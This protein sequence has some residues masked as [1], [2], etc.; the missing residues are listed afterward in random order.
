MTA[1]AAYNTYTQ[2]NIQIESPEKLIEMLYEG[3]IRFASLAKKAIE[4][5]NVEKKVYYINRTTAI[6]IELINSLDAQRGGEIAHYLEGLYDQQIKFLTEA[7]LEND[8]NKIDIVLKVTRTLLE[9]WR[10]ETGLS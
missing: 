8:P 5:G 1:A 4:M 7:N 3:I 9:T 6:F 2:N 10:E